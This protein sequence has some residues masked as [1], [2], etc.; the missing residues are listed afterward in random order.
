MDFSSH[1]D[2]PNE[3]VTKATAAAQA[4][5]ADSHDQLRQRIDRTQADLDTAAEDAQQRT[6]EA[7][8]DARANWAPAPHPIMGDARSPACSRVAWGLRI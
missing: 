6:S 1:F 8:A 2:H 3:R 5:A 4:A 7:A